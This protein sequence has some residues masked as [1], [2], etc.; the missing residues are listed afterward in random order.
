MVFPINRK[1]A[2]LLSSLIASSLFFTLNASA[3]NDFSFPVHIGDSVD[4]V[5]AELN[6]DVNPEPYHNPVK[7][8]AYIPD[9]MSG[10]TVID[11]RTKGI[12]IFFSSY[13]TVE[14]IRF[15]VPFSAPILGV[16]LGENLD[17]VVSKLGPPLRQIG[18]SKH[19]I[20]YMYVLNDQSYI[21]FNMV[22]QAVQS[23]V[24][25]K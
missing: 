15:D 22:E 4:K 11:L 23:V 13:G 1:C 10:K 20:S 14:A 16:Y 2:G 7:L 17:Q 21:H 19:Y 18:I 6:T 3:Q 9:P 12:S 8:P 25:T 5:K 24:L